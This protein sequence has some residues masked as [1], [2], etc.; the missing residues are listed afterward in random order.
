MATAEKA[1]GNIFLFMS[2]QKNRY[3]VQGTVLTLCELR[4]I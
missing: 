1:H 2:L 4:R 3:V